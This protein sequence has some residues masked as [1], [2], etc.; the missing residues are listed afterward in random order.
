MESYG[1]LWRC[2]M[3]SDFKKGR[4]PKPLHRMNKCDLH[5]RRRRVSLCNHLKRQPPAYSTVTARRR[6]IPKPLWR[7]VEI[8]INR[9]DWMRLRLVNSLSDIVNVR[10]LLP[11]YWDQDIIWLANAKIGPACFSTNELCTGSEEGLVRRLYTIC[12]RAIIRIWRS[13]YSLMSTFQ[14]TYVIMFDLW[15]QN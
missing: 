10:N 11:N 8:I 15:N 6:Q 4:G 1:R 5:H 9:E 2:I 7:E 13:S 3:P 14:N 12:L